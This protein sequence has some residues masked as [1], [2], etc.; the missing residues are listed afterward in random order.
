MPHSYLK[1]LLNNNGS[2][3]ILLVMDG[4]GDIATTP[5]GKTALETATTPN[6]DRLA[7]V[8]T[9]GQTIPIRYGITPGSGPAHLALF[10]YEPL[11][12]V[13]GRGAL[14]AAGINLPVNK[15]DIA[16]RGN[17]CTLD[18]D[19]NVI[20]RRAGRIS[21]ENAAPVIAKLDKVQIRG[22][23]VDVRQVKEYRF[24]IVMRGDGLEP[25]L[26]DTDPQEVGVPPLKVV[27]QEKRAEKAAELMEKWIAEA[28]KT[29]ADE[30]VANGFLLR[31]FASD[32]GLP[33][34]EHAYE[35]KAACI[36]E[37]PMYK[38]VSRLVGMDVLDLVGPGAQGEF[39]TAKKYWQDHDFFFIHIKKTDSYGEDGNLEGKSKIIEEV[40]QALPTLLDLQPDV[41]IVTGDHSTP[42]AMKSHSWHPVPF[43]IWAPMTHRT[44]LETSFTERN[45]ARGGL[46][47]FP[48]VET[49]SLALAHAGRLNK[50]GA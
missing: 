31:G 44:D 2:K 42:A 16:A 5:H 33:S 50:F 32:P 18:A 12:Y 19:G 15:G 45:C 38:G 28:T 40:D 24:V 36:A 47:T 48:A 4:L 39:E 29:L 34:Y 30:P 11:E 1:P 14:S 41:L 13:I 22:V 20:D 43:L 37:Y 17:L 46:G 3:I 7:K 26:N 27:A 6:L 8:G 9:L 35:L 21:H 49:M 25:H 10:G 23:E